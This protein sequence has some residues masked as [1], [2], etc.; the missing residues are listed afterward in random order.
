MKQLIKYIWETYMSK[1]IEAPIEIIDEKTALLAMADALECRGL[2]RTYAIKANQTADIVIK[3]ANDNSSIGD[4]V[5]GPKR[6]IIVDEPEAD[7]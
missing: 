6:I 1:P 7:K 2:I 4:I 5:F 3:Q